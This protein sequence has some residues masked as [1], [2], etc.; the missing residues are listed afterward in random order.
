MQSRYSSTPE[1]L[2]RY[3]PNSQFDNQYLQPNH[4]RKKEAKGQNRLN[5]KQLKHCQ[6]MQSNEAKRKRAKI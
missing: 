5:E 1:R 2:R 4:S 3:A 6:V